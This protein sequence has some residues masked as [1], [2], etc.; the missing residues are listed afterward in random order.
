MNSKMLFQQTLL[1]ESSYADFTKAINPDNTYDKEKVI[2]SLQRIGT[3][4]GK[5]D[6]PESGFSQGQAEDFVRHWRIISHIK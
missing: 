5:P 2:T 6:D 3:K 4:D 1:A